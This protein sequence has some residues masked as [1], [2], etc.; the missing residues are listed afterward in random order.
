MRRTVVKMP[1]DM[2]KYIEASTD[3]DSSNFQEFTS[4]L[5]VGDRF[6]DLTNEKEF[7]KLSKMPRECRFIEVVSVGKKSFKIKSFCK[8]GKKI[9]ENTTRVRKTT[10]TQKS[11]ERKEAPDWMCVPYHITEGIFD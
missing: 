10:Y 9:W 6:F 11:M 8:K 2:M 7:S 4:T 1:M 5:K 3:L